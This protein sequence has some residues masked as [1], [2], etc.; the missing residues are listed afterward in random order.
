MSATS[1]DLPAWCGGSSASARGTP[2]LRRS[3]IALL[4]IVAAPFAAHAQ[5]VPTFNNVIFAD[6]PLDN[7]GS[8]SLRMD[9]YHPSTGAPPFPLVLWIHGGGWEGGSFEPL[10]SYASPM[11][12]QGIAIASIEYRLSG[13]AE[14]P[15]QIHD[16]KGAVR[17]LRA[18]AAEY[19]LNPRRVACWGPSAGGHLAALLTTSAAV[20]DAEG[21]IGG[22]TAYSS[23]VLACV[24]YF[25]PTDL[26]QMQPDV[27]TPP[28]SSFNHD[29]PS[30]PE[31]K[32]IGFD[33][34]GQ[35]IGVLRANQS[36]ASPPFPQKVALVTLASPI[37]HVDAS[38]APMFIAHG[39]NDTTVPLKQST[40]LH[41]ALSAVGVP[42]SY[43]EVPGAGHGALGNSIDAQARAFLLTRL[44]FAPSRPGDLDCNGVVNASDV[45]PFAQAL[46]SPA[47]YRAGHP[48]CDLLNAD[49]N[50][51]G[52]A[53]GRD[54]NGFVAL[55]LGSG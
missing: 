46:A 55:L 29:L 52:Y 44:T 42:H 13:Q 26:L 40:R 15:A 22:N 10:A 7:G 54:V 35:G 3:L 47:A 23:A 5:I 14:F 45:G 34:V 17:F 4:S 43:T 2:W 24:D 48:T 49:I 8:V 19:G 38:D 36:N 30:S 21:V 1:G 18:H 37:A 27:T 51:D 9:I 50:G 6:A 25:G 12:L 41:D 11:L 31:S 28:G 33:G 32:L 16:I 39:T 20:A 53:D